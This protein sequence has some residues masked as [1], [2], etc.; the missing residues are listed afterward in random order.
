MFLSVSA[1][2]P[3]ALSNCPVYIQRPT[4][5]GQATAVVTWAAPDVEPV[6]TAVDTQSTPYASGSTIPLGR[7]NI[8]QSVIDANFNRVSCVFVVEVVGEWIPKLR[9]N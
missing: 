3:L 1:D 9:R 5:S 4:D 6:G 2:A 7:H 8:T